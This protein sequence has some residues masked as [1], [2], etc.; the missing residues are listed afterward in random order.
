MAR[1]ADARPLGEDLAPGERVIWRGRPFPGWRWGLTQILG[2]LIGGGV[3][4]GAVPALAQAGGDLFVALPA[5]IGAGFGL[6]CLVAA[7]VYEPWRRRNTRYALTDRRGW[8]LR[9]RPFRE[10]RTTWREI[11]ADS[12]LDLA[13][14][15]DGLGTVWFHRH[16]WRPF[17][18]RTERVEFTGFEFIEDAAEVHAMIA[19][20]QAGMRDAAAAP[21]GTA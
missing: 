4:L 20:I 15:G 12:Y 7:F 21:P 2:G 17:G 19:A 6:A 13:E 16:A 3:L 8:V 10:G 5:L 11:R 18:E 9:P 14:I 1:T